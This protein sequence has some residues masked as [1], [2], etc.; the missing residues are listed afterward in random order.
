MTN[1]ETLQSKE[2]IKNKLADIAKKVG[3]TRVHLLGPLADRSILDGYAWAAVFLFDSSVRL[4]TYDREDP[5]MKISFLL[6]EK[7]RFTDILVYTRHQDLFDKDAG[8][9]EPGTK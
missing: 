8:N 9:P 7:P 6:E 5:W 4:G 2:D 1:E 3:A